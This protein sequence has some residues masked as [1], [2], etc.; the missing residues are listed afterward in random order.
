MSNT[1]PTELLVQ[2]FEDL[3]IADVLS[4]ALADRR[5]SSIAYA[6]RFRH[7]CLRPSPA[8]AKDFDSERIDFWVSKEISPLVKAVLVAPSK[9]SETHRQRAASTASCPLVSTFLRHTQ[10]F[11]SLQSLTLESIQLPA[12]SLPSLC[13]LPP[14]QS[15][16]VCDCDIIGRGESRAPQELLRRLSTRAFERV[17]SPERI[18]S[19]L[20]LWWD[21]LDARA[22][23]RLELTCALGP[24]SA[25][26]DTSVIPDVSNVRELSLTMDLGW[27]R[28][29]A[30]A[31]LAPFCGLER[32]RLRSLGG[33]VRDIEMSGVEVAFPFLR[34]L[35]THCAL[36]PGVLGD[37]DAESG[38]LE[39]LEICDCTGSA[40][41]ETLRSVG[42]HLQAITM[43]TLHLDTPLTAD[44]LRGALELVPRL[45]H[46]E[47]VSTIAGD[48]RSLL[49]ALPTIPFPPPLR[50][51]RVTCSHPPAVDIDIEIDSSLPAEIAGALLDGCPHLREVC[52]DVG[53]ARRRWVRGGSSASVS[54]G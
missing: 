20:Q 2:I 17:D 27:L 23:E 10:N 41:L 43:L 7:L 16:A 44:E 4:V 3:P 42:A 45:T 29:D 18:S 12:S 26:A 53:G 11:T 6:L 30:I 38:V 5:L 36:L 48:V 19:G 54:T 49:A 22:L 31:V 33:V 24:W 28:A 51:L 15:L 34:E 9:T 50:V 46:L 47:L 8:A 14:L 1:L 37:S 35:D 32:L 52:F 13:G 21:I 25:S 39:R 40:L